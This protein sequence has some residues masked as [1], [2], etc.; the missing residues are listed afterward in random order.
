MGACV[1]A[2]H[3]DDGIGFLLLESWDWV[4]DF[5]YVRTYLRRSFFARFGMRCTYYTIYKSIF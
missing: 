5:T 4:F 1:R 2:D 3:D